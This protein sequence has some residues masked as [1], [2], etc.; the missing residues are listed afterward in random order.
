MRKLK[1]GV[2]YLNVN[3]NSNES[4]RV[5]ACHLKWGIN[6]SRIPFFDM[7]NESV[8]FNQF[9]EKFSIEEWVNEDTFEHCLYVVSDTVGFAYCDPED[10]F[11]LELGKKIALTRAQQSAFEDA[12]YFW[13]HCEKFML[14]AANRFSVIAENCID[15]YKSCKNHVQ[16]LIEA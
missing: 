15:S 5:V 11:D 8:Q 4:K 6:L 12:I 16:E 3:Y 1:T 14:E 2:S 10:T 9:L 13:D 7:L